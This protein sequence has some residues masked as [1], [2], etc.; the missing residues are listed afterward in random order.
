MVH[1]ARAAGP[2]PAVPAE[3][4]ARVV[5]VDGVRMY[6]HFG[7]TGMA[8][9]PSVQ[10]EDHGLAA[11]MMSAQYR[12]Q[13]KEGRQPKQMQVSLR[14]GCEQRDEYSSGCSVRFYEAPAPRAA[15]RGRDGGEIRLG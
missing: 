15:R 4:A 10:G 7:A 12:T 6:E 11:R 5:S 1:S 2:R 14:D 13:R 3:P 9:L 8:V